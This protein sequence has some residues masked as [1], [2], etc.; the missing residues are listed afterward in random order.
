MSFSTFRTSY[1]SEAETRLS[2]INITTATT[3]D[4]LA[5]GALYK[6]AAS[7]SEGVI[8]S[9]I[10]RML[11]NMT[12]AALDTWLGD[13]ANRREFEET[14]D[15]AQAM[16]AVAA[17]STAMTAVAASSTAMATVIAS[18]TAMTAVAAS[19][20]AM[21]AVAASSTA[22]ATVIASS[23]AMTAV[24]ASS[25]AMTAVAA[26]STAMATV[27]ASS[28]AMTDVF[29]SL[30]AKN[31]VWS[32]DTA[33]GA[34]AAST[35]AYDWLVVNKAVTSGA[36]N[37]TLSPGT[38][39]DTGKSLLLDVVMSANNT[40]YGVQFTTKQGT[41]GNATGPDSIGH[42]YTTTRFKNIMAVTD[43]KCLDGTTGNIS[44]TVTLRY[45][46]MD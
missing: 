9:A 46:V 8:K 14:L 26:S 13:I 12:G 32:S 41:V 30:T 39:F 28:T 42:R 2:A 34:I 27:I 11:E 29:N 24:A 18:S 44:Y 5:N 36:I 35:V 21:T 7:V 37:V 3:N 6:M 16:N 1:L 43:L 10:L 23:T 33:V 15:D 4:L 25:T 20:T 40:S 17:S 38:S 31:A 45:V 19:S 22:M